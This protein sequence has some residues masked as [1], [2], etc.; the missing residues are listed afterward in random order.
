MRKPR[1]YRH[2]A[3]IS[4][5]SLMP[6]VSIPGH[7]ADND[8]PVVVKIAGIPWF[9]A[10]EPSRVVQQHREKSQRCYEG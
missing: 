4:L 3:F 2:L 10:M 8:V 7:A 5:L 6:F 1:F 9:T